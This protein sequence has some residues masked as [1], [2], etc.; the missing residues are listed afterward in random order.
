MIGTQARRVVSRFYSGGPPRDNQTGQWT[1]MGLFF[2]VFVPTYVML[3]V[4]NYVFVDFNI[5]ET[6]S[7]ESSK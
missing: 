7:E 5:E 2:R 3:A 1:T 4:S 6:S